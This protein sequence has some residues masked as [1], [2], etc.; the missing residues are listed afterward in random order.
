VEMRGRR[1]AKAEERAHKAPIKMLFPLTFC[2]FPAIL[3]VLAYP[4]LKTF[5]D[6]F[7]G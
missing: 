2:I 3:I 4:G 5:L 1:R 7:N 6:A